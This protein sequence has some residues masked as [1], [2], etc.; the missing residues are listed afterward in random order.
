M[1]R[2]VTALRPGRPQ[3]AAGSS[4]EQIVRPAGT[5]AERGHN[6]AGNGPVVLLTYAHSGAQRVQAILAADTGLACTSGT[7]IIP[8]CAAAAETWRQIED[9]DD[10]L[11]SGLAVSTIRGLVTAQA[12]AILAGAGKA[13]W[14]E[15]TTGAPQAVQMFLQIFPHAAVLCVHRRCPDVIAATVQTSPWGLRSPALIPYLLSYPGNNVGA[16]AAYWAN[17]TDELLAF[18]KANPAN[19]RRIRLEDVI[20]EPAAA[21]IA[22]RD[23]LELGSPPHGLPQQ[24][25]PAE[26]EASPLLSPAEVPA[27]LIPAALRQ[28]INRLHAELGYPPLE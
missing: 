23:W 26:P 13:R 11:M 9:R 16:T 4:G 5:A 17:S 1:K 25:Q 7:G 14:C 2:R 28:R 18:E 22:V 3:P 20:A 10:H 12:T 6:H 27:E 21:L 8:Q 24:Y 15:L 19:T